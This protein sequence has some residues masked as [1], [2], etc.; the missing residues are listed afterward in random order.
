MAAKSQVERM[1]GK[2]LGQAKVS[3][4]LAQHMYQR[5]AASF[6][7][8]MDAQRAY[9]SSRLEYNQDL[10]NYWNAVYQLE[11]AAAI[12]LHESVSP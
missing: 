11:Q 10:A 3:R 5:G 8:F 12:S 1:E 2:L 9:V 6:I 7:D 4:D